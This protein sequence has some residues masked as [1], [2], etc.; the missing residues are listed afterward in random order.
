MNA[1][2]LSHLALPGLLAAFGLLGCQASEEPF[3]AEVVTLRGDAYTR[4]VQHGQHCADRI[5][6]L[7]TGLLTSSILPYLNRER[8]DISDVLKH[9]KDPAY[10]DGRFSYLLMLESARNMEKDIPDTYV[11]E[12]HGIAD[13][14]GIPYDDILVL[15]T[16][17][18]TMLGFRSMTFFIRGIQAPTIARIEFSVKLETDGVDNDGDGD[19]DE[20]GESKVDPYEPRA[21]AS[22][23][24][25]PADEPVKLILHD[26]ALMAI[27]EGV[28]PNTIRLQLDTTVFEPGSPAI[29]TGKFVEKGYLMAEASFLPQGGFAKGASM[30][31]LVQ[32]GDKSEVTDPPPNH[33]RYMRDERFTF[34]TKGYGKAP[35]EVANRGEEDGRTQPPSL[36]FALKGS[37][38]RDGQPL[39]A[40]HYALLDSNTSHKHTVL[41]VVEP[42]QGLRHVVAG[43]AGIVGGFSGMNEK[44]L[45]YAVN[46]SDSLDNPMP[47]AVHKDLFDALLL[48]TGI[49]ITM[50]GR[51]LLA[52]QQT[53]QEASDFVRSAKRSCGWNFLLA[54]A[55]GG[56]RGVETDI[57]FL[58]SG[59]QGFYEYSPDATQAA[60]LDEWGNRWS[61]LGPDDLE[62]ASHYRKN[63]EDIRTKVFNY[64]LTPQRYWTS[65]Y[66]R[67]LRAY[68]TM[69]E[70]LEPKLGQMDAQGAEAFLG[71]PV[72]VDERDSMNALVFELGARKVHFA[73]GEVPATSV[74][75][76]ETDLSSWKVAK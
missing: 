36:S 22:M 33:A 32:A 62:M 4:G 65:F 17:I 20:A 58:A 37:A 57:D 18:D 35:H 25:V 56:Q 75:W 48:E 34:T 70:L 49:P 73:M 12:M 27:P 40:H 7:Y 64:D 67:S 1:S 6:S 23:V 42:D 68:Y 46:N 10:D 9:Y 29:Q 31:L 43:W 15:N 47:A 69:R 39:L 66:F 16:F 53:V 45:A 5:R 21:M 72:L 19:I 76:V 60:N 24:E 63:T 44:G 55:A 61:S 8:P 11:K 71:T 14:S 50:L 52:G 74:P 30:S 3:H 59:D 28:D 51:E 54:D 38:T 41:F 2:R 13:G 26:Q